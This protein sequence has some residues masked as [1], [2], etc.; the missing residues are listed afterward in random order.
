[1]AVTFSWVFERGSPMLIINECSSTTHTFHLFYRSLFVF[2]RV[3]F[4]FKKIWMKETKWQN[5]LLPLREAFGILFPWSCWLFCK[6]HEFEVRLLVLPVVV[7]RVIPGSV[8]I[9]SSQPLSAQTIC[10]H[11]HKHLES[12]I[13]RYFLVFRHNIISK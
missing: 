11:L 3:F 5:I 10:M 9:C 2:R 4:L 6:A 13:S 12:L 7:F 8:C 1:M